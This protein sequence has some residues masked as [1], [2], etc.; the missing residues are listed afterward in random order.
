MGRWG[1]GASGSGWFGW[2]Q[3]VML[4][5]EILMMRCAAGRGAAGRGAS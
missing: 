2:Q 3:R 4:L 5:I 1:M